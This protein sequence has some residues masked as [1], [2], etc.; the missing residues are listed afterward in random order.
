MHGS[1]VRVRIVKQASGV[2]DGV[3]LSRLL[4]GRMYEVSDS[5]ATLLVVSHQAEI[6]IDERPMLLIPVDLGDVREAVE[7]P[8][9]DHAN[10]WSGRKRRRK[11]ASRIVPS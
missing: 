5:I 3:N 4:E 11:R 2:V 7:A 10:D 6:V 1:L 8:V 9:I